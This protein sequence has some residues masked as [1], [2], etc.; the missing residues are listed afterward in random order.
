[1]RGAYV[2]MSVFRKQV[3]VCKPICKC[4]DSREVS[5]AEKGGY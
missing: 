4:G 5:E 2:R 1:M 3:D